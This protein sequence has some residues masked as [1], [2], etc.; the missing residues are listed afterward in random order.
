MLQLPPSPYHPGTLPY[1]LPPLTPH[2][3]SC[4]V[5]CWIEHT[6]PHTRYTHYK[7]A[8]YILL[9][10]ILIYTCILYILQSLVLIRY[11]EKSIPDSQIWKC[12]LESGITLDKLQKEWKK[13]A[14]FFIG[15]A[16]LKRLDFADAAKNLEEALGLIDKDP[17]LAASVTELKGLIAEATR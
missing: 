6:P 5:T 14:L 8:L 17:K 7:P 1:I 11:L 12:L 2:P 9:Y 13:K 3:S 4:A 16:Q 10:I 15:K